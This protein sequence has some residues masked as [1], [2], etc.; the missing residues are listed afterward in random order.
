MGL[1]PRG[2]GPPPSL[3]RS[4]APRA[5]G[6]RGP[7]GAARPHSLGFLAPSL[8][9]GSWCT[10]TP[11]PPRSST[12]R[13]PRV[14]HIWRVASVLRSSALRSPGV[15]GK[16]QSC[17]PRGS[18]VGRD[19]AGRDAGGGRDAGIGPH[20]ERAPPR[21]LLRGLCSIAAFPGSR[22][23]PPFS[24]PSEAM[25]LQPARRQEL[26]GKRPRAPTVPRRGSADPP[27]GLLRGVEEPRPPL[28]RPCSDASLPTCGLGAEPAGQVG[29]ERDF[30]FLRGRY[31]NGNRK[32]NRKN[33]VLAW[34]TVKENR[35]VVADEVGR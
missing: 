3:T 34:E 22:A 4:L 33:S 29:N 31:R 23:A 20:A 26:R 35:A 2:P 1:R 18:A 30:F 21:D 14:Q 6:G 25:E 12:A 8:P 15:L 10:S 27:S 13:R 19:A 11:A 32:G 16:S 7:A 17:V 5:Q 9:A 24:G 28:P